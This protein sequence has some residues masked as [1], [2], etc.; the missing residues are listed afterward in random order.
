[1]NGSYLRPL[2][3][4]A[5]QGAVELGGVGGVEAVR[6][7]LDLRQRTVLDHLVRALTA[8]LE[9]DDAVGVAVDDERG[10]VYLAQILAEVGAPEGVYAIQCSLRRGE[11]RDLAVIQPVDLAD[12]RLPLATGRENICVN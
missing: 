10:N 2:A 5:D 8:D 9:R 7:A 6:G 12:E 4:E 1:M 3:D 11:L